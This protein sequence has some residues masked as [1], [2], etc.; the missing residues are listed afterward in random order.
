MPERPLLIL[1]S[2][3]PEERRKL[4]RLVP[5]SPEPTDPDQQAKSLEKQFRDVG[6]L[7]ISDGPGSDVERVLVMESMKVLEIK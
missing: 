4:R 2:P 5:S 6:E 1:P 7:F 3:G